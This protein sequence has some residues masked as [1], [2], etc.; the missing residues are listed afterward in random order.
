M[1]GFSTMGSLCS[2]CFMQMKYIQATSVDLEQSAPP[3]AALLS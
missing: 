3:W 2:A 1:H